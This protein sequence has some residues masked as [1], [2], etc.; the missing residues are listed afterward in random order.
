M[1]RKYTNSDKTQWKEREFR[2]LI[3]E[4]GGGTNTQRKQ[5][6]VQQYKA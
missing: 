1:K 3:R 2:T 6:Q 4:V 5:A